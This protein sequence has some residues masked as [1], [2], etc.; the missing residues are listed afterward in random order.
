MRIA[1]DPLKS[2]LEEG[3]AWSAVTLVLVKAFRTV[4][5]LLVAGETTSTPSVSRTKFLSLEVTSLLSTTLGT[6]RFRV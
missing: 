4:F 5:E 3:L 6:S 1:R 2:W